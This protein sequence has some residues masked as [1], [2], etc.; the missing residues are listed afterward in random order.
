[1]S[2][3]GFKKKKKFIKFNYNIYIYM[4][5]FSFDF[6]KFFKLYFNIINIELKKI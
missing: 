6:I 2:I 3:F 1:M 4:F 5:F